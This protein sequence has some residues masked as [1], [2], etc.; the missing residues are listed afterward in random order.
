V[1]IHNGPSAVR[2]NIVDCRS[3]VGEVCRC[4][5]SSHASDSHALHQKG[6]SEDI[7]T[8]PAQ[9]LR[10]SAR[11]RILTSYRLTLRADSA[12]KMKSV[13]YTPGIL[14]WP[15][16]APDSSTPSHFHPRPPEAGAVEVETFVLLVVVVALVD[17]V[18][19]FVVH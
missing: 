3:V 1:R 6:Y 11:T 2:S 5:R 15:N 16:S 8:L 18:A 14:A 12:G 19:A 10:E 7:E 17:V 4:Q 9:S 13:P